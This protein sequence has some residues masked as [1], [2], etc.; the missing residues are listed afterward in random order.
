MNDTEI[1]LGNANFILQ[2]Q[3]LERIGDKPFLFC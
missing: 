2:K 3:H 1:A